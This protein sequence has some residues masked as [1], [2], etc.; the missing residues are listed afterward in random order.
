MRSGK[1]F[2]LDPASQIENGIVVFRYQKVRSDR[3]GRNFPVYVS[4]GKSE[5]TFYYSGY[6]INSEANQ[7]NSPSGY[8]NQRL[9]S[10][11]TYESVGIESLA[12]KLNDLYSQTLAVGSEVQV[13]NQNGG[14]S[15]IPLFS[16][17]NPSNIYFRI[18]FLDFL[19]DWQHSDLFRNSAY[20]EDTRTRLGRNHFWQA[21]IAM[22]EFHYCHFQLSNYA[23]TTSENSALIEM[24]ETA[25]AR[26]LEIIRSPL[27]TSII[28]DQNEW[29]NDIETEHINIVLGKSRKQ[30]THK[31]PEKAFWLGL[32]Q[33]PTQSVG[34][35]KSELKDSVHWFVRRYSML[36]AFMS[37]YKPRHLLISLVVFISVFAW[38]I[39]ENASSWDSPMGG[40]E[41]ISISALALISLLVSLLALFAVGW[42][43]V[44]LA[45]TL[46]LASP[47]MAM[48]I[49]SGWMVFITSGDMWKLLYDL[50][51]RPAV[52]V[53]MIAL[54]LLSV[55]ISVEVRNFNAPRSVNKSI[56][57]RVIAILFVGLL[58]SST[59]ALM[60]AAFVTHHSLDKAGILTKIERTNKEVMQHSKD[61]ALH[62]LATDLV[63]S[64][65]EHETPRNKLSSQGLLYKPS[66]HLFR[67]NFDL[68]VFPG[69]LLL[70]AVLS[71]CLGIFI[72]LIFEDKSM[73]EPI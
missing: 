25:R 10:I 70:Q 22:L 69:M 37:A 9:F 64:H 23:L 58:Y 48:G 45:T 29:F 44:G 68:Y 52:I 30:G 35:K 71:L 2:I 34:M 11:P 41:L 72:Q 3:G 47:R 61:S 8:V 18:L 36:N 56:W 50:P 42:F 67:Q 54:S 55:F 39:A 5:I 15:S 14:Y 49:L 13:N 16:E 26:W 63:T 17:S 6:D 7:K 62:S 46:S 53:S 65:T 31:E 1:H 4:I 19:F 28:T 40:K 38:F 51:L 27:A 59:I 73:T 60:S 66:I 24:A 21:I 32:L 12:N 20:Y 43:K 33:D 57:S